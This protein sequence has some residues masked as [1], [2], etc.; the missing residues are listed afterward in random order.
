MRRV[1]DTFH[2]M[3]RD[4]S[5][6]RSLALTSQAFGYYFQSIFTRSDDSI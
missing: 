4:E 1:T 5:T 6:V 3:H 2:G